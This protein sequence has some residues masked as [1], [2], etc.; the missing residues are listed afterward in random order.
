MGLRCQRGHLYVPITLLLSCSWS[1][2]L[3]L[4]HG[5]HCQG[6]MEPW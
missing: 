3:G 4:H 2:W 5:G 6:V 1:L